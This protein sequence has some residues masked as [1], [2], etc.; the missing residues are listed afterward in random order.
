MIRSLIL[1]PLTIK[2][3]SRL[4]GLVF[5][6][7]I[8][9]Q[10]TAQTKD[11][12]WIN[13]FLNRFTRDDRPPEKPRFLVYPTLGY[14]PETSLELGVAASVYYHAKKD[15]LKNRLSEITLFGFFTLRSQY[16]LWIDNSLFTDKNHWLILGR[17][18]FQYF[19]LLYYGIGPNAPEEDPVEVDGTY[20]LIHQRAVR[21][22]FGNVYAGFQADFQHLHQVQFGGDQP[23]RPP[24]LGAGGS[25]NLGIGPS[26]VFDSRPNMLNTR[27]GCFAELSWLHYSPNWGGDFAFD[28]Y[29]A[30][31][32]KYH[33]VNKNA[34]FAWQLKGSAVQGNAPFNMLG[35]MGNEMLMRG[36]YSGRFRD[37]HY[38]AAQAE[39]RMLPFPF[40]KRLGAAVFLSSGVVSP[41]LEMLNIR[42]TKLAG[43][44]GLRY[45]I[46]P[47]K[48]IFVRLDAGVTREGVSFYIFTGEAF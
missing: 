41:S 9:F 43:G 16:G 22:V 14:A 35:L 23:T 13:R 25:L 17:G 18:R 37:R 42:Q 27:K 4:F 47:Q 39:F 6:L 31:L 40:S 10:L 33:Q 21:Q 44:A 1:K 48:D 3:Q 38:Y 8:S 5:L 32:R 34:V 46:L 30:E 24:P 26:L 7:F 11:E 20:F 36:Y 29:S 2:P 15:H 45:L 19:P 12:F 28:V